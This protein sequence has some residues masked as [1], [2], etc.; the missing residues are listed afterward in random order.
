MKG[1]VHFFFASHPASGWFR[2]NNSLGKQKKKGS[3]EHKF[4][5]SPDS[6][7]SRSGATKRDN[8]RHNPA[9]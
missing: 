3:K 1:F 5:L 4:T 6:Y 9:P 2:K 8:P 7:H